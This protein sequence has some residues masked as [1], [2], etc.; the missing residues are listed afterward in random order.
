MKTMMSLLTSVE[1]EF[2]P[3][4]HPLLGEGI[5]EVTDIISSPYPGAS[6]LPDRCRVTFDRR[7]LVNGTKV[8][9]LGQ[10]KRIIRGVTAFEPRLK[11][12]VFLA[13]DSAKCYTGE[14]IKAE[15]FAPDWVFGEEH[16]FVQKA[17]S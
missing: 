13:V 10:I 6:V 11:A 15:R 7:L 14:V 9:V 17:L 3:H 12:E 2:I 4:W 5:L 16:P 1:K 8:G